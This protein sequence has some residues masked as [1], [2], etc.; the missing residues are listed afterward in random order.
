MAAVPELRNALPED[1]LQQIC[2]E[3]NGGLLSRTERGA[4][5]GPLDAPDEEAA[6]DDLGLSE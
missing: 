4:T 6:D 3:G 2:G 1:I 5:P